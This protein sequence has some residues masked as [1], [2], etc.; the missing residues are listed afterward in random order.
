MAH[1]LPGA[2]PVVGC[3]FSLSAG[4]VQFQV[5]Q[6]HSPEQI[7]TVE[8][9]HALGNDRFSAGQDLV[10]RPTLT[11]GMILRVNVRQLLFVTETDGAHAGAGQEAASDSCVM[12]LHASRVDA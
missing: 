12:V 8:T 1:L 11:R 5:T 2:E 7:Q 10:K 9:L 4:L 6:I 3:A